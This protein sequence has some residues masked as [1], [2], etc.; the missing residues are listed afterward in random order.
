MPDLPNRG[1][2]LAGLYQLLKFFVGR[3]VHLSVCASLDITMT[4]CPPNVFK[5]RQHRLQ[6]RF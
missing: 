1:H 4:A 5:L 6:Y 3:G 2:H